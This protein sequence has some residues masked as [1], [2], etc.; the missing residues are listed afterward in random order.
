MKS[1][2]TRSLLGAPHVALLSPFLSPYCSQKDLPEVQI[3]SWHCRLEPVHVSVIR[4]K[5]LAAGPGVPGSAFTHLIPYLLIA[6]TS[7]GNLLRT[8]KTRST[9]LALHL[10]TTHHLLEL[11]SFHCYLSIS[12]YGSSARLSTPREHE[13][14]LVPGISQKRVLHSGADFFPS[15]SSWGY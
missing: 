9:A 5:P 3:F 11:T 13:R 7:L 12:C 15:P 10:Q 6:I 14:I 4:I 1:Q 2:P 8:P